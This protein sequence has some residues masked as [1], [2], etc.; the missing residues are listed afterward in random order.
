MSTDIV[1]RWPVV[2]TLPVEPGDH[3][4]DGYLTD[5]GTE[6]MFALARERYFD[7]CRTVDTSTLEVQRSAAAR[8]SATVNATGVTISVNVTEVYPE[9]FTMSARIRPCDGPGVAADARCSLFPGGG[10]TNAM[11]DEFIA[12]AHNARHTH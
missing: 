3:D 4:A 8:G 5:A 9:T 11:R 12:L 2:I 10:V 6:R 7:L 1:S